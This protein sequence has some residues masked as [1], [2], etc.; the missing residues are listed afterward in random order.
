[1][2]FAL[3]AT[4]VAL[5]PVVALHAEAAPPPGTV[6]HH[7]S[8][9][10]R[11]YI[12]SPSLCVMPDG[13]YIASHDLFGPGSKEHE[14]AKARLYRSSNKGA[15]WQHLTDFDGYFW[16]GIFVHRGNAFTLG[17]D[18]HHGKVVI[19]RSTDSG[20]TW[21]GPVVLAEGE[22]HTAPMPL[23]EHGGRLWRA[24]EDAMGGTKWGE[25][26]RARMMSAPVDADLLDPKS[27]TFSNP[28]PRD[29]AWL[30]GDFAAWL[31]GNAV[32]DPQ[33]NIV[34]ILRVDNPRVPEKAAIVRISKDGTTTTFDPAEDFIDFPG[35]AKKF[36]IRQD[37]NG[38]GYWS[39]ASIIPERH[40]DAGRPGGIRNTLAL[41]Q[42]KDLRTW[43]TRCVLLYHPDVTKHG[44]QYVDWQFEGDDLIAACRT[45]WD[46][47]EGGARNN[48]DANL[49]T[50]HRWKNFRS[51]TRKDDVAMPESIPVVHE[52]ALLTIHGSAFEIAPLNNG[53]TAFSNRGYTWHEVP[54]SLEGMS[55]TRFD[56]GVKS[57]T[58]VIA[59]SDTTVRIATAMDQERI[60]LDGWKREPLDFY[61]DD[62]RKT[63]VHV[64]S[65][66]LPK[67]KT[68]RLPSGNWTGGIL[69]LSNQ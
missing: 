59:K 20:T 47:G 25:R 68:L 54:A 58:D 17:T 16:T 27:W 28:L 6:I 43:E 4:L 18:K 37:P 36:T 46:D 57:F 66:S 7:S 34:N 63:R 11:L 29:P 51:L 35:G 44:F 3:A 31:E 1:M 33:G 65:R 45:A 13:S 42:S 67:D 30:G 23:I 49:L 26:Y 19:R 12:G 40:A 22:W 15:S 52:T 21:A 8:A 48:H 2:N 53:E 56:G 39:I 32:A 62:S 24:I 60:E 61:Y 5:L 50:F 38:D 69:I 55:F 64:F 41:I 14:S 9:S 10:S